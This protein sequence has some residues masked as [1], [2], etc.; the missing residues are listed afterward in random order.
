M[1]LNITRFYNTARPRDYSASVAERGNNAGPATW[2]AA[3]EDSPDYMILDTDDKRQA[4]ALFKR[5]V[6]S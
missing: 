5:E 3:C 1:E 4:M 2:L 6:L